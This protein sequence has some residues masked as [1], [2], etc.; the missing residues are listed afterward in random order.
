M[1]PQHLMIHN[2]IY[3]IY[4]VDNKNENLIME[5]EKIHS[6]VIDFITKEIY[7]RNDLNKNSMKLFQILL[8]I[9]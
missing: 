3:T 1:E 9:I 6:G 8:R 5:D 4:F 7:I 2:N